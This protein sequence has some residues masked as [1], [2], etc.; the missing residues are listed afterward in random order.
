MTPVWDDW[1]AEIGGGLCTKAFALHS[2]FAH[3]TNLTQRLYKIGG[4]DYQETKEG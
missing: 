2:K 4:Y 3:G 1:P